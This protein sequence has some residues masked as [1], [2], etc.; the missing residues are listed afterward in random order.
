[1]SS[2]LGMVQVT[3]HSIALLYVLHLMDAHRCD[4]PK[5]GATMKHPMLAVQDL[6]F[7][8]VAKLDH[9]FLLPLGLPDR[10]E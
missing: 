6:K 8:Q 3:P 5:E 7:D 4:I 1:M 9:V 2:Q 10:P